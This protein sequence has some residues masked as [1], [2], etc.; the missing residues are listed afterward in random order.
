MRLNNHPNTS[1]A[2]LSGIPA[3]LPMLVRMRKPIKQVTEGVRTA[4]ALTQACTGAA[5]ASRHTTLSDMSTL[6]AL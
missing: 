5:R 3:E 2:A 6:K 1:V 4:V